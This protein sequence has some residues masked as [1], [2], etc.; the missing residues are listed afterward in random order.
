MKIILEG[1]KTEIINALHSFCIPNKV[2]F[3]NGNQFICGDIA[4]RGHRKK[5]AR[6]FKTFKEQF[7]DI[8]KDYLP[9]KEV[10]DKPKP[11]E[12]VL[13]N[14]EINIGFISDF[15]NGEIKALTKEHVNLCR[16]IRSHLRSSSQQP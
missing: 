6:T 9:S 7:G 13:N 1:T 2:V 5:S 11:L 10:P 8:M 15:D 4:G 16:Q 12:N 14:F 3:D